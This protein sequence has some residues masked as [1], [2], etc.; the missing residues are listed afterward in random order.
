MGRTSSARQR[1][2]NAASNLLWERSYH[3]VTVDQVCAHAGVRKGSLYH[4]FESKSAVAVAALQDFWESVAKPA[5]EKHFC[6]ANPPLAR[7]TFFLEWLERLQREKYREVGK[8]LGWPFFTLGCELGASEPSIT[9]K[10][11]DVES[12]ELRYFELAIRDAIAQEAIENCVPRMA[13]LALRAAIDGI[14]ARA[15]ILG[16]PDELSALTILPITVLRLRPVGQIT[17]LPL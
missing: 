13:A 16:E 9:R 10:L 12:T 5:Y 15:R 11:C 1:V 14:L 8:V 7:I 2:L 6:R 17:A 4:F 3:S